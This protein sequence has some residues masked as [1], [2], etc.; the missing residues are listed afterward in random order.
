MHIKEMAGLNIQIVVLCMFLGGE[1]WVL[2]KGKIILQIFKISINV[3]NIISVTK[4]YKNTI[5]KFVFLNRK[6]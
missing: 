3:V 5:L 1:K 2:K 4:K 6:N